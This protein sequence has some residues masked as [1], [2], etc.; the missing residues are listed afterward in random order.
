[1]GR[2]VAEELS[3][4]NFAQHPCSVLAKGVGTIYGKFSS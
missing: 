2:T 3:G 1:M 4:I